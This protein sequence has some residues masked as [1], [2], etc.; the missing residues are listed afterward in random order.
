[1][2]FVVLSHRFFPCVGIKRVKERQMRPPSSGI[3]DFHVDRAAR[4]EAKP[5]RIGGPL[6]LQEWLSF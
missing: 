5:A 6:V 2:T 1:M 3:L 4:G